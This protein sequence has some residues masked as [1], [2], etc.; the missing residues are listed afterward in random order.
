MILPIVAY[1]DPVLRK[2]AIEI[3]KD[4]PNLTELIDNMFETMYNA[5]GV[6]LAAPQVG[7]SL[8]LFV[9]DAS[10]FADDEDLADEERETLKQFKK[11]FINPTIIEETGEEWAFNEGCLSIPDIR[12]DI[13]RNPKIKIEYYDADFNKHTEEYKGL[14]ARVIQHEYD[15][16]EGI[17]FTDKLSSL[18]K[19]LLKGK[20]SNISKGKIRIDY[21]MRFPDAKKAR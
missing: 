7:L 5:Y 3:P 8:R 1:G 4:Y 11:V 20:L 12:E 16:I 17:L 6:G 15:H 18:K 9:I 10:A 13:T 19:R 2:V 21:K 14:A